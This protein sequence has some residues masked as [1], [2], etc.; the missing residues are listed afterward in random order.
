MVNALQGEKND[1]RS[2]EN[3]TSTDPNLFLLTI[4]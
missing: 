2:D 1:S 3:E 4:W